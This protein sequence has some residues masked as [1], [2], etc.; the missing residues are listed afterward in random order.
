MIGIG[1][2]VVLYPIG[3]LFFMYLVLGA[4]GVE[5]F[6]SSTRPLLEILDRYLGV[7]GIS[8]SNVGPLGLFAVFLLLWSVVAGT[9]Q[10]VIVPLFIRRALPSFLNV[11]AASDQT[12]GD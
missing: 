11:D 2:R 3:F 5:T 12:R 4:G 10:A 6:V 9:N 8:L 1:V 7:V